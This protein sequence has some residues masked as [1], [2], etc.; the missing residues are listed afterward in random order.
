MDGEEVGVVAWGW[1]VSGKFS[2]S[3]PNV[4]NGACY[5]WNYGGLLAAN[6]LQGQGSVDAFLQGA[7]FVH[8]KIVDA[9]RQQVRFRVGRCKCIPAGC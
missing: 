2:L 9:Q 8:P 7:R 3:F 1:R 4:A 5:F 6:E